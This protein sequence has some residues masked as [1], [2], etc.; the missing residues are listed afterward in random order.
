MAD[1]VKCPVCDA[2][3]NEPPLYEYTV[4]EAAAHFCPSA[5]DAGRNQRL[6]DCIRRLWNDGNCN[7]F[8]CPRCTFGFGHPFVGGDE[9]FYGILH[10]QKGYPQWK[11]DFDIA[12]QEVVNGGGKI[13][14][15]GAGDGAFLR[16]LDKSWDRFAVEGS[17]ETRAPLEKAGIKVF[18]DLASAATAD[19]ESFEVVTMF[20][21]LE[22]IAEFRPV[23]RQAH[24]L[25][26]PGG[27]IFI[28]VPDGEAMI[29]QEKL[30]N[31]PDMPP[32]HICK[33]TP[34]SLGLALEQAGF[35]PGSSVPEPSSMQSLRGN[36]HLK[37]LANAAQP[38]SLTAYV[39]RIKSRPLRI[40]FMALLGVISCL[41][42]LPHLG[43]LRRGGAFAISATA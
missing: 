6:L 41:P 5:R 35:K 37:V 39:Y 9:V 22:H 27:R 24:E 36:M 32:N 3:C 7:V 15:I 14:D 16:S 28:T 34:K 8:Q 38:G 43:G 19:R 31:A 25:L 20:Q 23:L 2:I 18:R 30:V 10:E 13:L 42:L 12:L 33:W 40:P 26:K 29:R 11:W 4:E 21:S 17:E 1:P